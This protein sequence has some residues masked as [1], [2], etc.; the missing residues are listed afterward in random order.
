M[1][2][3]ILFNI[4][5]GIAVGLLLPLNILASVHNEDFT[6]Y[7]EVDSNDHIA[8]TANHIDFDAYANEDAYLYDDKGV[9]YF[10]DFEHRIDIKPVSYSDNDIQVNVM[11]LSNDIDDAYGLHFYNKNSVPY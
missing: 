10:G 7:T 8:V 4:L 1:K 5:L 9:D 3:L 2:R 6:T 11:L